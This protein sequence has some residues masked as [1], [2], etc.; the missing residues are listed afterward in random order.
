MRERGPGIVAFELARTTERT[1]EILRIWGAQ[2][3]AAARRSLLWDLPFIAAYGGLLSLLAS[4][5]AP[6][7]G[8]KTWAW[9]AGAGRAIAV[10]AL[11]AAA[12]DLV[13]NAL[14]WSI[15]GSGDRPQ[16]QPQARLA[17]AA[18]WAKFALLGV[19]ILW[20]VLV[21]WPVV[22]TAPPSSG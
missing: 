6:S 3:Q 4:S 9:V 15:L 14:L 7:M 22:L 21:A 20:I 10:A 2:G 16:V 11:L 17:W 19:V 5:A 8:D 12:L 13:E 18:A 1:S